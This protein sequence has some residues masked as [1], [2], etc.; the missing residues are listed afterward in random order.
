MSP[1][2]ILNHSPL[3]LTDEQRRFYFDNGYLLAEGVI[4]GERLTSLRRAKDDLIE[5]S[6]SC[7]EC[8]ADFEFETVPD[9]EKRLRQVLCAAD[10][11]ADLWR[12]ASEAPLTDLAA[13][14]VGP[15]I[16]F[17]EATIS[18]KSPGGRGFDWHQDI[19][20]FPC[21]NL[22][23]MMTLTF[24]E[25]VTP[26]MGPTRVIP[27]SHQGP[28]YDHY[29]GDGNWLG[30]IGDQEKNQVPQHR[31]VD[32]TGPAGSVLVTNCAVLHAAKPNQS[33]QRRPMVIMGY[34]SADTVN[35]QEIPYRSQ[36]RWR[37]VKGIASQYVHNDALQ[38]KM[39]PD[40]S[41]YHGVRIDNL[42]QQ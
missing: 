15:D 31:A 7:E 6:A 23:P 1:E 9:G 37:I 38:L 18:F 4:D 20:F 2:D 11:H 28:I 13:D 30:L 17:R 42:V 3:L 8:P 32:V 41:S 35:Y 16:L 39:P 36:Y 5:R 34:S 19:V 22:S 10:H 21:S 12:Y 24:L 40:W 33:G 27:G 29:D 26:E 25:D 14:L